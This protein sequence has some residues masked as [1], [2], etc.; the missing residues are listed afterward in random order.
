MT[1]S[2]PIAWTIAGSDSG[3]GAG[4]QADLL[5]FHDF[6]VHGCSAIT[7]LTAQNSV[8]VTHVAIT[9]PD[10]L[11]AQL[12]AL[13][14]DLPASAI[15]LGM[16]GDH[17]VISLVAGALARQ[18]VPVVL[19]PVMVSTSGA[20]LL[21]GEGRAALFGELFPHVTLLT[22]N[23]IEA[24]RL[25]GREIS[26][27]EDVVEAAEALRA[28]G[29]RAVLIKGGHR[30]WL[31]GR[32]ADYFTDGQQRFWLLAE[33][34]S[35]QHTHGSGCTLASAITAALACGE[36]MEDAVVLGK[37]YVTQGIRA[38]RALGRGPGPVAHL[39]YPG[40]LAD[41]PELWH[42]LPEAPPPGFPTCDTR[43]L[44]AYPVVDSA[45]WV[46]RLLAAGAR[47]L[48]LRIKDASQ[49]RLDAEIRRAVAAARAHDA[50]LFI[51]D[52]WSLAIRHGAYGVHLG[53][54]DLDTA[55]LAAIAQAGL[56]LGVSN[57]SY[58][59]LARAHALGPSYLAL[60]PVYDTTTKVMRF[61]RQG[62]PR[63]AE[64]VR[65]L[66]ERYP[67]VAIGGID[68]ARA[69]GVL[70]TGVG[71]VAMVRAVTEAPDYARA[72]HDFQRLT[73]ERSG[74]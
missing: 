47:T 6:D 45:D 17:T 73:G 1:Q 24:E 18:R 30:E 33:R 50:R 71:S 9:P 66:G 31:P 40:S 44:G 51:N 8:A 74:S 38:A 56:C 42:T 19:D 67:L 41:L 43:S 62:L 59:E 35:S 15:K 2:P 13:A 10:N 28:L 64:W 72:L 58:A 11:Q 16:L 48:Q 29:P 14:D 55:D 69:P 57:H 12:D 36:A 39:G 7:A 3:G 65:L 27:P 70:A 37:M 21:Q 54:E 46:E 52:H 5:T 23:H 32:S 26:T 60:G 49:E 20:S 22:P 63:L 34:I 68:L 53:Q 25:L 4:I 61:A